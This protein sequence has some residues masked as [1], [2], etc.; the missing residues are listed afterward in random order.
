MNWKPVELKGNV[1]CNK[2]IGKK[3]KSGLYPEDLYSCG[4]VLAIVL[5]NLLAG[6]WSVDFVLRIFL[7]QIP[8]IGDMLIGLFVAQLTVPVGGAC[9]RNLH[10]V[11]MAELGIGTGLKIQR[12]N[13]LQVRVLLSAFS[14]NS[15]M[16]R[17]S[18]S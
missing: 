8:F 4:C 14:A 13:P 17:A 2:S 1:M 10:L 16:V 11:D 9:R 3:Y 15:S 6:G 5:F 12:G 7:I 18:G